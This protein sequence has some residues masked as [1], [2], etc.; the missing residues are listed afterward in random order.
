[1]PWS[2]AHIAASPADVIS[3]PGTYMHEQR[4]D[5]PPPMRRTE[6]RTGTASTGKDDSRVSLVKRMASRAETDPAMDPACWVGGFGGV[7][8]RIGP[9][10][11]E[12]A[13]SCI[14]CE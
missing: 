5:G 9:F 12:E 4:A 14:Q 1:M 2:L 10:F 3:M 7:N 8:F 13:I 11:L 6:R